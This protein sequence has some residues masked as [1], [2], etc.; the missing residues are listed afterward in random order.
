MRERF[1]VVTEERKYLIVHKVVPRNTNRDTSQAENSKLLVKI[2][3]RELQN[4]WRIRNTIAS[5][6]RENMLVYLSLDIIC[7][8]KLTLSLS[9]NNFVAWTQ[10]APERFWK[11][12]W[13]EK[14]IF[15]I[16]NSK[17]KAKKRMEKC[18]SHYRILH[19]RILHFPFFIFHSLFS[20]SPIPLFHFPFPISHSPFPITYSLFY[21]FSFFI[22][23]FSFSISH[24]PF[25][26]LYS[27]FHIPHSPLLKF[28][29]LS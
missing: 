22:F 6:L 13:N 17:S 2:F 3:S 29:N 9:S 24:S 23:H 28:W 21:D 7:S 15:L 26:I 4:I 27:P 20:I 1:M 16:I 25:S 12:T 14:Y 10:F 19:S 5:T 8:S 18:I 11:R